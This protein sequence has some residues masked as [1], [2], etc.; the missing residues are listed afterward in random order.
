[1]A[2]VTRAT[3][4]ALAALG[5]VVLARRS[6]SLS[7]SGGSAA[8]ALG[9]ITAAA[10]WDWAIV[11]IAYFV[12]S[13]AVSKA[14]AAE[15]ARRMAAVAEK[16][17]RRDARQV[18]ANG[19][20]YAFMAVLLVVTREPS[21]LDAIFYDD[22]VRDFLRWAALAALAASAADTWATEI[23]TL[24]K[25]PPKSLFSRTIVPIGMSGGVTF[26]GTLGSIAGATVVAG[27]GLLVGWT[28]AAALSALAAGIIGSL[29]DSIIG[30]TLQER[31][32]CDVCH[33]P[34]EQ[35]IH[36][37]GTPT[38]HTGG[39]AR[40]DN[41]VVNLLATMVGAATGITLFIVLNTVPSL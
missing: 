6:G 28:P 24:A 16:G 7:R 40:I 23:G 36:R 33:Q 39:F 11:L 5:V 27:I 26:L 8:I 34:T 2:V 1:M 31:R 21:S 12:T 29:A 20:V 38:R 35:P 14:G 3:L 25:N 18:V 4:G 37:C 41:D 9:T 13:S 19:G 17:G 22:A 32:Y 10:G 30:A 15:K